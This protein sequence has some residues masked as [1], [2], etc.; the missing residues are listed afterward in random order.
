MSA[1]ANR[2]S[3][4][5]TRSLALRRR[6]N[7][8]CYC[9]ALFHNASFVV[10]LAGCT[11]RFERVCAPHAAGWQ[12]SRQGFFSNGPLA[13]GWLRGMW[14][15]AGLATS[16]ATSHCPRPSFGYGGRLANPLISGFNWRQEHTP[17]LA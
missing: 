12:Y 1:A 17:F 3:L 8:L 16:L 10:M 15:L 13:P 11:C 2:G 5:G 9:I 14:G 7:L 6:L 4:Q